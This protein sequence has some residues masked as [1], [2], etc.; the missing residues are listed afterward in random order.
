MGISVRLIMLV[1]SPLLLSAFNCIIGTD[2]TAWNYKSGGIFWPPPTESFIVDRPEIQNRS[3]G[4]LTSTW[5]PLAGLAY[6]WALLHS[7][8]SFIEGKKKIN[9]G[10]SRYLPM[11][12]HFCRFVTFPHPYQDSWHLAVWMQPESLK[13]SVPRKPLSRFVWEVLGV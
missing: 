11:L 10:I 8:P 12:L 9:G 7:F 3:C 6:L 4:S 1:F 2:L 13:C 5:L